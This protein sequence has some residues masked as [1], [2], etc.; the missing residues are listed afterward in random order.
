MYKILYWALC[1]YLD[2]INV[3]L[4]ENGVRKRDRDRLT[5]PENQGTGM[6]VLELKK[7]GKGSRQRLALKTFSDFKYR[8]RVNNTKDELTS[9]TP[10]WNMALFPSID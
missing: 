1:T 7:H 4:W 8:T 9:S 5:S 6:E 3:G 2:T 10:S